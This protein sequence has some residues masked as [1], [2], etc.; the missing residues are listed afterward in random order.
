MQISLTH[1]G[2]I[3]TCQK[4]IRKCCEKTKNENWASNIKGEWQISVVEE[5]STNKRDNN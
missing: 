1:G 3:G 2:K 4:W 5:K